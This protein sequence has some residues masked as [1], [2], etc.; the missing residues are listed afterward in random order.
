[1][2]C[3]AF[4]PDGRYIASVRESHP[5]DLIV[6]DTETGKSPWE[7]L[8]TDA[9]QDESI[10]SLVFSPD[11]AYLVEAFGNRIAVWAVEAN[12]FVLIREIEGFSST[13]DCLAFS[14][15]GKRF[16]T[17]A[18][19]QPAQ[20]WEVDTGNWLMTL[21]DNHKK[22]SKQ[23][24]TKA[25]FAPDGTWIVTAD[26]EG[27][28]RFWDSQSGL[29]VNTLEGDPTS[30]RSLAFNPNGQILASGGSNNRVL[31]WDVATKKT[32]LVI[33][34]DEGLIPLTFSPDNKIFVSTDRNDKIRLWGVVK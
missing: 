1:V 21:D 13:V 34:G 5:E 16:L 8:N 7:S 17:V 18:G 15:D 31:I 9:H 20:V 19:G 12:D 30:I 6:W 11:G 23:Y 33:T 25:I 24:V 14:P 3:V 10:S 26:N 4:S 32:L 29:L 22:S 27:V 2:N 28:I